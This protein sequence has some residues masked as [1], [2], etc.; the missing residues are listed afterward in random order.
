MSADL[1]DIFGDGSVAGRSIGS[2]SGSGGAGGNSG[3]SSRNGITSGGGGL[4]GGGGGICGGT[5]HWHALYVPVPVLA[6][7]QPST[8]IGFAS[9]RRRRVEGQPHTSVTTE[10]TPTD[11]PVW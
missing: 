2:V 1:F 5:T 9:E 7:L 10:L 4:G 11:P 6:T 3:A 8:V